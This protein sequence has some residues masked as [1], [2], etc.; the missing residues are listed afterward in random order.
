MK[1]IV[2]A[3]LARSFYISRWSKSEKVVDHTIMMQ[4]E[5]EYVSLLFNSFESD[6]EDLLQVFITWEVKCEQNH[7]VREDAGEKLWTMEIKSKKYYVFKPIVAL[8]WPC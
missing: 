2:V 5:L 6:S 4:N 1:V 3:V 7:F 8:H